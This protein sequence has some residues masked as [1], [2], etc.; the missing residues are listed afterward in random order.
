MTRIKHA[1]VCA[2]FLAL[3][4]CAT[5]TRSTVNQ[6]QITSEPSGAAVRTS[7]SQSC[8][9]PCTLT[10]NRKD[11]FTVS[12]HLDGYRDQD[13]AVKTQIA[14]AGAAGFAG[15]VIAG[16]I[17]GMGVDAVTGATL[18]QVPNPVHAIMQRIGPE[19]KVKAAP[20]AAKGKKQP[21][22]KPAV[23][24]EPETES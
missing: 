15:N 11:E 18:E 22:P 23:E 13:I 12:F 21:A 3:G 24:A 7:L 8:Q 17:V 10:V 9:T 19:P 2:A 4:G 6:I 1:V 20:K 5:V 14:S 16:G